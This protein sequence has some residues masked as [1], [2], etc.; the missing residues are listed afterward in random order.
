MILLTV[1]EVMM[2]HDEQIATY[3]GDPGLRD[4]GLLDSAVASFDGVM[5]HSS[6]A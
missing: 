2:L 4:A 6:P 1:D 3:G 5:V